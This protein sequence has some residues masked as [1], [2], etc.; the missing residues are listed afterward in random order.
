[1]ITY[2]EWQQDITTEDHSL[3]AL[4]IDAPSVMPSYP[5]FYL[6][7]QSTGF[8]IGNICVENLSIPVYIHWPVCM[9]DNNEGQTKTGYWQN[10]IEQSFSCR[11][12]RGHISHATHVLPDYHRPSGP[13][14]ISSCNIHIHYLPFFP[15]L[16]KSLQHS[17]CT[18]MQI[19]FKY[20]TKRKL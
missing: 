6:I 9:V 12:V 15:S 20:C 17:I 10:Y 2:Y 3:E 4:S 18:T 5:I 19:L 11:N 8:P 14:E 13:W 1:M 7:L 16:I